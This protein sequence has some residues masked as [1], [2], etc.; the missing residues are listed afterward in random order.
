M[1]NFSWIL[2]YQTSLLTLPKFKTISKS[3]VYHILQTELTFKRL[4]LT[5]HCTSVFCMVLRIKSDYVPKLYYLVF[6]VEN[7]FIY[8]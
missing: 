1:L 7:K 3:N 8:C 5:T 4:P 6:V 2:F